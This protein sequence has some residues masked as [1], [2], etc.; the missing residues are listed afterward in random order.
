MKSVVF[1]LA[2]SAL[3][4]IPVQLQKDPRVIKSCSNFGRKPSECLLDKSL[5]YWAM[6]GLKDS[7]KRGRPDIAYHVLLNVTSSPVYKS[8]KLSFYIHTYDNFIIKVGSQLRP[9]KSY[10]RF[11]G[12]IVDLYNKRIIKDEKGSVLLELKRGKVKDILKENNLE[13]A[14][15]FDVNGELVSYEAA[16]KAI[17]EG[18]GAF[19]IGGFPSG[20]FSEET[21]AL[22]EKKYSVSREVLDADLV[23]CR[24]VYEIEK[25][26]GV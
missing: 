4:L 19:V 17:L 20:E 22:F 21:S 24:I 25:A 12:L 1:I 10:F 5:H 14:V 15:G 2:E 8:D 11:E 6:Q 23:A 3:E 26:L 7:E 9:P 18:S 16:A 13:R